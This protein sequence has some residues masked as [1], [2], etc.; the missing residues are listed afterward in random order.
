MHKQVQNQ[1]YRSPLGKEKTQKIG[2]KCFPCS[3]YQSAITKKSTSICWWT[4]SF[5]ID[6]VLKMSRKPSFSSCIQGPIW[7]MQ[8]LIIQQK[9]AK[10]QNLK[11]GH[12]HPIM[13][14]RLLS[15]CLRL[16]KIWCDVRVTSN[17]RIWTGKHNSGCPS[18][19]AYITHKDSSSNCKFNTQIGTPMRLKERKRQY[20]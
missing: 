3:D 4:K 6:N 16:L 7:D 11:N 12:R 10:S 2:G 5:S 18:D 1:A 8:K 19:Y 13:F 14:V 17:V 20:Y 15:A 9:Y